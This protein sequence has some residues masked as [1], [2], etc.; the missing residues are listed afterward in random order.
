[1]VKQLLKVTTV[2]EGISNDR[3]TKVTAEELAQKWRIGIVRARATVK[4]TT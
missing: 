3:H 4:A 2:C 1:M